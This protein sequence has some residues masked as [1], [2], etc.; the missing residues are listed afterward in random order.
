MRP[1]KRAQAHFEREKP[2]AGL[3]RCQIWVQ[4]RVWYGRRTYSEDQH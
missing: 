1:G 2:H 3:L 4:L